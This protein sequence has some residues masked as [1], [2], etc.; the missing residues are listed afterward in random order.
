MVAVAALVILAAVFLIVSRKE[1]TS[2][3]RGD[4]SIVKNPLLQEFDVNRVSKITLKG[5]KSSVGISRSKDGWTIA[6]RGGFPANFDKVKKFVLGI[7]K[8]EIVQRPRVLKTQLAELGLV[9]PDKTKKDDGKKNG[10]SLRLSDSDGDAV[11]S[12]ILGDFHVAPKKDNGGYGFNQNIPDGRY[13]LLEGDD[14][15]ALVSNSLAK[16]IPDPKAWLDKNGVDMAGVLS[17]EA[18]QTDGKTEWKLYRKNLSD[19]WIL[20]GQKKSEILKPYPMSQVARVFERERFDDVVS[21]GS[22]KAAGV[23]KDAKTIVVKTLD[24]FSYTIKAVVK[25][26]KGYMKYSVSADIPE[27]L[28]VDKNVMMD[29]KTK[30][31]NAARFQ[32]RRKKL[33]AKLEKE[34]KLSKWIYVYPKYVVEKVLKK[35]SDFVVEKKV[36]EKDKPKDG[37]GT[38]ASI[39]GK[40]DGSGE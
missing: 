29:E 19:A 9:L 10:L 26:D 25:G 36:E 1:D 12:L 18:L 24:K 35:R 5:A 11:A 20:K 4:D 31:A 16:A 38:A 23:L 13:V 40:K 21:P 27:K 6:E 28:E 14:S 34:K 15:P 32:A 22:E 17:V 39:G 37:N 33:L 30:K 7:S 8:L 2:W 3:K